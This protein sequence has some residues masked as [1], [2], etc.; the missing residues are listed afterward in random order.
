MTE[1]GRGH[2]KEQTSKPYF[3]LTHAVTSRYTRAPECRS[4]LRP[5]DSVSRLFSD[6]PRFGLHFCLRPV[7]TTPC[8]RFARHASISLMFYF[9]VFPLTRPS[10]PCRSVTEARTLLLPLY[11]AGYWLSP[12]PRIGCVLLY[13]ISMYFP[14]VVQ[15]S[16][17]HLGP[18]LC[19]SASPS[20]SLSLR[21]LVH[22][23][24]A[25]LCLCSILPDPC[26]IQ[27]PATFI[28]HYFSHVLPCKPYITM[29]PPVQ[30]SAE[31]IRQH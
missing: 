14:I 11:L 23:R 31:L 24:S 10:V 22:L 8:M 1:Q 7:G 26:H 5:A 30:S 2:P 3:S 21:H 20:L 17:Y 4:Y 28:R 19:P 9:I 6:T 25:L 18:A 12:E 15:Q 29:R 16:E 27:V 13:L